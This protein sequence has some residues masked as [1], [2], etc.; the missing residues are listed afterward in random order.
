MTTTAGCCSCSAARSTSSTSCR[1]T[2]STRSSRTDAAALPRRRHIGRLDDPQRGHPAAR[3]GQRPLRAGLMPSTGEAIAD[4]VYFGYASAGAV[5]HPEQH[6]LLRPQ[7]RS[8]HLRPGQGQRAAE[9]ELGTRWL[10]ARGTRPDRRLDPPGDRPDLG[11]C[12]CR[13]WAST[14][15]STQ[16]EATT[17]QELYNTE[18][19]S[20]RIS[21]WTN[22]TPDPD[23]MMGAGLDIDV[24]NALHTGY[25]NPEVKALVLQGRAGA[26]SGAS[27]RRSTPRSSSMR[28]PGMPLHL[29]GRSPAPVRRYGAHRGL[30]PQLPGQVRASRTSRRV[31]RF[32]LDESQS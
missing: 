10:R 18:Q 3:R 1:R 21:A 24:Q 15:R 26:R 19:Y 16:V 8:G 22:D 29:H 6:R 27:A 17:A 12:T 31:P 13:A 30:R 5:G 11:R 2:R 7:R 4:N 32:T 20:V 9:P 23:E 14:S 25:D 28:Q